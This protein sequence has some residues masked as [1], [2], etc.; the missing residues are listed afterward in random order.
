M[1]SFNALRAVTDTLSALLISELPGLA[2][3]I[4]KS[5][6]DIAVSTS[7]VSL[8]LYRVEHNPSMANMGWQPTTAVQLA[9]PPVGINLHY[10]VTPYGPDQREM[11]RTLGEV[12]RAFH[13]RPIVRAGDAVL[14]PDLATM[15]EELRIVP[16]MLPLSEMLDLWRAFDK[17]P[18]RLS[19]T[20][21]VSAVLIDSAR[22]RTVTRV[23]ERVLELSSIS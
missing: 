11:Q 6:A 22:S 9:G 4:K 19:V 10:L 14:S 23:Q 1:S 5:P 8:Y 7:L 2:V 18:Y 20:Y 3:E 16:R 12:L 13:D 17:V 15:T 21:E